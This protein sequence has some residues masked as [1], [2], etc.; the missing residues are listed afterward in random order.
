LKANPQRGIPF[1]VTYAPT[2]EPTNDPTPKNIIEK[3][4]K[5]YYPFKGSFLACS[6]IKESITTSRN[7]AAIFI[8]N[9]EIVVEN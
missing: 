6:I 7:V 4:C 9:N 3:H 2:N 1:S 5:S 8:T